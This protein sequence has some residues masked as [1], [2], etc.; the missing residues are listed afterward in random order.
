MRRSR[1]SLSLLL[2]TCL[3]AAAFT[4]L[5]TPARAASE[6]SEEEAAEAAA[7]QAE[8]AGE[9]DPDAPEV[10]DEEEEE[11]GP[12]DEQDVLVL[13]DATFNDTLKQHKFLLVSVHASSCLSQADFGVRYLAVARAVL[14]RRR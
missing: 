9:T 3:L 12:V 13:T 8:A 11:E 7:L 1:G 4:Q 6:A 2:I 10:A 5:P 14:S